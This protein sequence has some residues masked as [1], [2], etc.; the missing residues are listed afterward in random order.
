MSASYVLE[1]KQTRFGRAD[2][3]NGRG[4]RARQERRAMRDR[5]LHHGATG[6]DQIDKIGVEQERRALQD[7]ICDLVLVGRQRMDDRGWREFAARPSA[8]DKREPNERRRI[9]E[10]HDHCAFA[11]GTIFV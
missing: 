7:R 2:F 11:G 10:Q 9:V 8:S 1:Q 6:R 4:D 3:G 5:G